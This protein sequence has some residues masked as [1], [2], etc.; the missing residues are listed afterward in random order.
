MLAEEDPGCLAGVREVL[1]GGDV[2]PAA[3]VARLLDA[4]PGVSVRHLYGPTEVTLC[5]VQHQARPGRRRAADRP[6]AG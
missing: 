6:A 3:A 1:T 4:C 2:V 5:A